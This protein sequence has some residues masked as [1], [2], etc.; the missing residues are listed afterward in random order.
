MYN[1]KLYDY[2]STYQAR[3]YES[4]LSCGEERRFLDKLRLKKDKPLLSEAA[5]NQTDEIKRISVNRSKHTIFEIARANTWDWFVTLTFDRNKVD[6]SDYDTLVRIVGNWLNHLKRKAPNIKYLAVSELHKDGIHYHF[7]ALFAD[8]EELDFIES[9]HETKDG[10]PIYNLDNFRFGFSTATRVSDTHRVALYI[11]KY[12]TKALETRTKGKR[13]F[14]ASKNVKRPIV[15]NIRVN[16]GIRE[17]LTSNSDAL[18][19][20]KTQDGF[21]KVHYLEYAKT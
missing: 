11:T 2:G 14:L 6:S 9:G 21:I 16:G 12:F 20:I 18:K 19:H 15:R 13:R 8:C 1:V 5:E 10:L 7:H 17:Y 3:I 4:Y